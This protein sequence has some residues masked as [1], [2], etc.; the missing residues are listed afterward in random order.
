VPTFRW[1][2]HLDLDQFIAAVEI[3]RRPELRGRPV[4]VGGDGDP[5]RPRQVVAT[6][7][8]EAR[9]SGVGSGMPMRTA[10]RR[11]PDAVFLPVDRTAYDDASEEVWAVVRELPVTVEVWGWDEGFLGTDAP[12]PMALAQQARALVRART[13]LT[14]CIGI[15]D[16]KLTAKLATGFAKTPPG[17]DLSEAPGVA[18]LTRADWFAV[19]G[20]RPTK[21]LWGIGPRTSAHLAEAGITTVAELAASDVALLEKRFGPTTGPWLQALAR[22]SGDREIAAE[23]RVPRGRSREET[24]T[25]D[26][27]ERPDIEARVA[28]L[29]AAVMQDIADTGRAVTHVSIKVRFVPFWTST[30]VRK[31]PEPG[32][33]TAVVADAAVRLLDRFDELRPIRL[34]G[35]R[36]ELA[37]PTPGD[38]LGGAAEP[39]QPGE[40]PQPTP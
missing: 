5:T 17:A 11:C 3:R 6:A 25:D 40:D 28:R 34:L 27:T 39:G 37:D 20:D 7:S 18:T 14:C 22:G 38:G 21:A 31:L 12:D 19:M 15:G 24:F 35:V 4:I 23:P 9:R 8:Y 13:Q 36:V 1:V 2:L 26:L 30:R 33:D 29:A 32:R 10:A 16:N